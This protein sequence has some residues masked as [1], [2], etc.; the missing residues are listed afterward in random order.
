MFQGIHSVNVFLH[1]QSVSLL[2][3]TQ[4][5]RAPTGICRICTSY[6]MMMMIGILGHNQHKVLYGA[7]S[8]YSAQ[9]IGLE[10]RLNPE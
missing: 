1:P 8:I 2:D 5:V 3:A 10:Q 9:V 6:W 7:H 4:R